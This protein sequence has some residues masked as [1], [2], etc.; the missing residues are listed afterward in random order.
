MSPTSQCPAAS[1]V[2]DSDAPDVPRPTPTME[3]DS[4]HRTLTYGE[5]LAAD[6]WARRRG[7][8]DEFI[9]LPGGITYWRSL[10]S[11]GPR[12]YGCSLPVQDRTMPDDGWV[13]AEPCSC[14][15]CRSRD[16]P[17]VGPHP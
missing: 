6:C 2:F 12:T 5:V 17:P 3:L 8:K 15:F 9:H 14:R 4:D 1:G 16:R 10:R 13:H 7:E 11:G